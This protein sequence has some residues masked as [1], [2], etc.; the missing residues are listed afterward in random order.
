SKLMNEMV[1]PEKVKEQRRSL[2][3]KD[4]E[5]VKMEVDTLA[6]KRDSVF[7]NNIGELPLHIDD[8]KSYQWRDSI[9]GNDYEVANEDVRDG[10]VLYIED[11]PKTVAGRVIQ[12]GLW[13]MNSDLTLRYGGLM[14]ALKEYNFVDGFWLGQTLSMNYAID[15]Y[16]S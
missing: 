1:E 11:N 13:K 12:G 15:K 4:I 9:S 2:E 8:V 5:K 10:V 14:G 16:K 3:I 6:W 7:W